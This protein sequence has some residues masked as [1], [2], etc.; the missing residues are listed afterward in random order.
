[1][2]TSNVTFNQANTF[3]LSPTALKNLSDSISNIKRLYSSDSK[4]EIE[5]NPE[6]KK[7]FS[8][9]MPVFQQALD[10]KLACLALN[11]ELPNKVIVAY[12]LADNETPIG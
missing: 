2:T 3:G 7:A 1:M 12:A 6:Y 8:K 4:D 9:I 5:E 10:L 11:I